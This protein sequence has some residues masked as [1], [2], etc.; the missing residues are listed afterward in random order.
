MCVC[1]CICVLV[2]VLFDVYTLHLCALLRIVR[3]CMCLCSLVI[4]CRCV[5]V[6]MC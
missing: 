2:F 6:L 3:H 4:V 1:M 5:D